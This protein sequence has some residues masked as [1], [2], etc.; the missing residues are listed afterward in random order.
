MRGGSA[1]VLLVALVAVGALS[2]WV[3]TRE[4][5][6][7][8][9]VIGTDG[10][11]VAVEGLDPVR[12][13]PRRE[14]EVPPPP[15]L[16]ILPVLDDDIG[17]SGERFDD[18]SSD[19]DGE[20]VEWSAGEVIR[21]ID[22]AP[23]LLVLPKWRRGAATKAALHPTYLLDPQTMRAVPGPEGRL[24]VRQGAPGYARLRTRGRVALPVTLYAPQTLRVAVGG[25]C[26]PVIWEGESRHERVLLARCERQRRLRRDRRGE[27]NRATG[28]ARSFHV[29]SDPDLL[30]NHGLAT[31]ENV[32][33]A[34]E[35]VAALGGGGGR[36]VLD[37][38]RRDP[39][40][41]RPERPRSD[42]RTLA[43]LARF[44]EGPFAFAWGGL[45]LL[46]VFALWRAAVRFGRP[47]DTVDRFHD[48]SRD[49][50][51]AADAR[52]M[53]AGGDAPLLRAHADAR[54]RAL[55]RRVLGRDANAT[56]LMETLRRRAPERA[57][58]LQ[59]LLARVTPEGGWLERFEQTLAEAEREL[60]R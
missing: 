21:R 19:L 44:F 27:R 34:R 32:V 42:G 18:R 26:E 9:T 54:M 24:A 14:A 15:V 59:D 17:R 47:D 25:G 7:G 3:W 57:G 55:A 28:P 6:L 60:V 53:L 49:A 10:L 31:G 51:I 35:L 52:V 40:A 13:R 38:S 50:M 37:T 36:T 23:T 33:F 12:T 41:E 1:V 56:Q 5:D 58:R 16:R 8:R 4:P 48:A 20:L 46:L 22:T 2:W 11:A 43:D 30:N 29:L 45:V 39:F